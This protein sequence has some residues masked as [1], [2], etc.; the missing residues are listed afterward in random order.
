[1]S[2]APIGPG[3]IV[4]CVDARPRHVGDSPTGLSL[5]AVY[6]VT[7]ASLVPEGWA[8]AG[9]PLLEI[10]EV[11]ARG[12]CGFYADRFRPLKRRDEAFLASL[13]SDVPTDIPVEA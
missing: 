5:A 8:D 13:L 12:G 6:T 1:M 4:E 11:F 7:K 2:G 3:D 10:R 9:E